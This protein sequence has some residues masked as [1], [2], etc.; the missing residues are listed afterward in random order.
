MIIDD[1]FDF[2]NCHIIIVTKVVVISTERV[3]K[4][5]N[6]CNEIMLIKKIPVAV[7]SLGIDL[8]F[9]TVE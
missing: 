3:K 5:D 2:V 1:D 8:Y 9:S 4:N 7:S 6:K